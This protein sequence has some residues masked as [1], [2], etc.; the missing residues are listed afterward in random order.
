MSQVV[1]LQ[2]CA[3]TVFYKSLLGYIL[4]KT[5]V[6]EYKVKKAEVDCIFGNGAHNKLNAIHLYFVIRLS[7]TLVIISKY[8]LNVTR[9][10]IMNK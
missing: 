2:L 3:F 8:N 10:Y 7:R 5:E 4:G 6:L 1:L 9:K